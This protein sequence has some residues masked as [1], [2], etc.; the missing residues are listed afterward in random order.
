VQIDSLNAAHLV[1]HGSV[2]IL[3]VITLQVN[4]RETDRHL[5]QFNLAILR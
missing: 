4:H 5:G 2:T 3:V 1:F